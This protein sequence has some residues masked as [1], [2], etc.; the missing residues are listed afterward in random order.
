MRRYAVLALFGLVIAGCSQNSDPL[1]GTWTANSN[2]G[3]MTATMDTTYNADGTFSGTI[4]GK[5]AE[6]GT[7]TI[8]SSGKWSRDAEK[9]LKTTI[10][11][12]DMKT[13]GLP[14]QMEAMFK[15]SNT[16]EAKK[17]MIEDMNAEGAQTLTWTGIVL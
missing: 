9:K 17:K 5:V 2:V 16:P 3:G 10:E 8:T 11:N 15:Q 13:A 12:V 4:V 6:Q 14:A 1:V 7:L